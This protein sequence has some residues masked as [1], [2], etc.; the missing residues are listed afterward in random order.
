MPRGDP[1][2]WRVPCLSDYGRNRR[3]NGH[4]VDD[5]QCVLLPQGCPVTI[6]VTGSFEKSSDA[7]LFRFHKADNRRV[8]WGPRCLLSRH[9]SEWGQGMNWDFLRQQELK[10]WVP[11]VIS[12]NDRLVSSD[13][14]WASAD[15]SARS[16]LTGNDISLQQSDLGAQQTHPADPCLALISP[17]TWKS[18]AWHFGKQR[19]IW[20]GIKLTLTD[21]PKVFPNTSMLALNYRC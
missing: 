2:F 12:P 4:R 13:V 7:P 8:C 1:V 17:P 21:S 18:S 6:T 19:G 9:F 5:H 10:G 3:E 15:L 16:P 14:I 20:E 11:F